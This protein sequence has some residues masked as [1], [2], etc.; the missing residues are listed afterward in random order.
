ME[1]IAPRVCL[2]YSAA[3][4]ADAG[5]PPRLEVLE[6]LT[7]FEELFGSSQRVD[8]ATRQEGLN[9]TSE[10]RRLVADAEDDAL[11]N[12]AKMLYICWQRLKST[13]FEELGLTQESAKSVS[14]CIREIED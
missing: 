12:W 1:S 13:D 8:E 4:M 2:L 3:A 5:L 11:N 9:T 6:F 7:R 14:D 10:A